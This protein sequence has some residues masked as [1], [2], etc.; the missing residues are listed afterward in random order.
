MEY[1]FGY[2]HHML[3]FREL[4]D[5]KERVLA[6]QYQLINSCDVYVKE[7]RHSSVY[8]VIDTIVDSDFEY[9]WNQPATREKSNSF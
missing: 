4:S 1:R 6:K 9:L 3:Y 5:Q 8:F 7:V 2:C